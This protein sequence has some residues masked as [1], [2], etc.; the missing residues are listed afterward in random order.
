MKRRISGLA[1]SIAL[2]SL[3]VQ[4][5]ADATSLGRG[6]DDDGTHDVPSLTGVDAGDASSLGDRGRVLACVASECPAGRA[7]CSV[8]GR[9]AYKCETDLMRDSN[10]CGACDSACPTFEPIHMISR[11]VDAACVPECHTVPERSGDEDWR[12]C[13]GLVDNGC[14]VDVL[15]NPQHCGTCGNA[16]PSGLPCI[17]GQCGCPSGSILCSGA[18][19][20]PMSNDLHCGGC[21]NVCTTPSDACSPTQP[22]TGY[23]CVA[24]Q[25]AKRCINN[26]VDCNDDLYQ[27]SCDGDGCEVVGL[28]TNENCGGCGIRC[29][30]PGEECVDEGNGYECAVP[31]AKYGTT[32][33]GGVCVDLLNDVT[34]CGACGDACDATGP[35]QVSKCAKGVCVYECAPGFGDCNGDASDGCE[36][37]LRQHPG[38]CGACGNACDLAAGQP[39]I[40]GVCLM[41][42]CGEVT[43]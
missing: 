14:E 1:T 31:C 25:C 7:T 40:D 9:P 30:K 28:T 12:N 41:K 4:S 23:G 19:V 27:D 24:G 13:D 26:A 35:N 42:E 8:E 2:V 22:N 37:D 20:D 43:N 15:A 5:C 18:C 10:H 33:C 6:F 29:T 34:A 32:M 39:C 16:C 38:H 36:I 17:L 11:C 21:D 3:S